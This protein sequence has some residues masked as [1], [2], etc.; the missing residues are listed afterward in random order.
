M[1]KIEIWGRKTS[2]NVQTVMWTVAE[3]GLDHVRH[4][5]GG[6]FGGTDTN[7]FLTINPMGLV[8]AIRDDDL[9]LFESCAIVRYLA[10]KYGDESFWP[11]NATTR[12]ELDQ[13]AEWSK[14]TVSKT[15]IYDVFWQL[16]RTPAAD[17]DYESVERAIVTLG[18]LMAIAE[19]RLGDDDYLGGGALSFADIIFGHTLYRYYTLDFDRPVTPVLDAYYERL[20]KRSAFAEHVMVDYSS[21]KVD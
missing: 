15:I 17:R 3:L 18:K 8:P 4:D 14:T 5:A 21:L 7:E 20:T 1:S 19:N 2:S 9:T 10:A 6:V 16:I 12:A 11:A 13:W